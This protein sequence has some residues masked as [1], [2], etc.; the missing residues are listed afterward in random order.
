MFYSVF[1][2]GK[3]KEISD[4]CLSK[5]VSLLENKEDLI[6][7][8]QEIEQKNSKQSPLSHKFLITMTKEIVVAHIVGL[9]EIQYLRVVS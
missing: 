4:L 3:I 9:K 6:W 7:L 5:R 1:I 8:C 2:R